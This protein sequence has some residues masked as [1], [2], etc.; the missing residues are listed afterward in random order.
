[1]ITVRQV[2]IFL[3]LFCAFQA[4]AETYHFDLKDWPADVVDRMKAEVPEVG[5]TNLTDEQL[6][7]VLKKLDQ[8]LQF[9]SL[10]VVSTT[11]RHEVRLVGEISAIVEKIDFLGLEDMSESEAITLTNLTVKNA[12]DEENLKLAT[13]KLLQ[14]YRDSGYRSAQIRYQIISTSTIKKSILF[15]IDARKQTKL[16]GLQIEGPDSQSIE[17]IENILRINFLGKVMTQDT[18]NKV[19][20]RVRK[21]LNDHGYYT[22]S[23]ASPQIV[24]SANELKARV[25]YRLKKMTRYGIEILNARQFTNSRLEE[26]VLKLETYFSKEANFG[27]ELAEKLKEFYVSEGYPHIEVPFF[28]RK[29]GERIIISLSLEE[30][31]YTRLSKIKVTGQYSRNEKFYI[32]KILELSSPRV[33][34]RSV[35]IKE[36]IEQGVKNLIIFLQNEGYVNARLGRVQIMTDREKPS[37]GVA[38]IQLE[39]GPKIIIGSIEF[40]GAHS[41]NSE[42][43]KKVVDL[44]EGRPLS[45]VSLEESLTLLKNYFMNLGY[46]EYKLLN[47]TKDLMT[48]SENNALAHLKFEI[49]QGP[50]VEVQSILIEGNNLTHDRL[51]LTEIDF[52]PGD[53]LT[54]AKINESTSRLLKTGH[55]SAVDITTVEAGTSIPQRTVLVKV[56]ERD[57]GVFTV[58]GG[59][60]N[61]NA[62]TVRGYTG[63]AYRN[64]GGWGRGV[65]A[66]VEGNYNYARYKFVESK[67]TLGAVEPYLLD[68]RARLRLNLT[69]A[70]EISDFAIRKVTELNSSV[71]SIEQDFT[72]H[73]IGIWD[74]FN[75]TTY[76]DRGMTRQDE[77]DFKYEYSDLV[78]G[79]TGP[80]LDFDYRDNLF[81]PTKGSFTRFKAEYA[82]EFNGSNKVDDF[83]RLTG[84]TTFYVPY[85]Q[86]GIVFAQSL[87][88]GYIQDLKQLGFGIP[89]DKKG[90]SL[91]GRT[92]I[93]GF[94][95]D[96]FFP[97]T[98]TKVP[99]VGPNYKLT[100]FSSYNLVKSE[101]RFPLV[102]KWDLSGAIFY[103]GGQ[104]LID[105]LAFPDN[106][107]DAVGIGVRYNTPV[108]P[109]NLEYGHKL[110]QKSYESEGS[111]HLSIGVF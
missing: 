101:L 11:D 16:S 54:P 77:I 14:F 75:V 2:A 15:H 73:F 81:N 34:D 92:T 98:N 53:V 21:E 37:E 24:F 86:T 104:V 47:E 100:S 89:F 108:G 65:S 52:K 4:N 71:L 68:T 105:G 76:V 111:F 27:V 80:T 64:I 66:R 23:L 20:I 57:P 82:S 107:R 63:A 38:N 72:S 59:V 7:L 50:R 83:I 61:E 26:D 45:L 58:G 6:N 88:A 49:Q 87:R 18:L 40:T 3:F 12:L 8:K 74:L 106:W 67:I 99:G 51:I 28:E 94:N 32:K 96:E 44:H 103:D 60:T 55:F 84:Q 91:G 69:R 43:L 42:V 70:R 29:Q 93:R 109:I 30:G 90:F 102:N 56:T 22:T 78:I 13:E 19:N 1:M 95:P 62:G 10:R 97:S 41:Q 46:I 5:A 25:V 39:E 31:V 9:N 79:S 36:D 33:D 48:Y 17:E 110:D 35:Y 85:E